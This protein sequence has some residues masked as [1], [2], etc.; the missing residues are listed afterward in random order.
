[1]KKMNVQKIAALA[2]KMRIDTIYLLEGESND[3]E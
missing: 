1:M 2:N 3:A